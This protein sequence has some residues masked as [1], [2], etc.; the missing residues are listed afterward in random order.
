LWCIG[1]LFCTAGLNA[2]ALA[3]PVADTWHAESPAQGVSEDAVARLFRRFPG[4]EYCDLKKDRAT[5]RSKVRK[6]NAAIDVV[7]SSKD[8][9]HPS[10][11]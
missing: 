6:S 3:A 9:G 7:S 5:G 2:V 1:Q 11:H 8:A 10:P 4:M